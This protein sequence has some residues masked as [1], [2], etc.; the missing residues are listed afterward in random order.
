MDTIPFLVL[1]I[2]AALAALTVLNIRS[3]VIFEYQRGLLY[4][5]GKFVRVLEPGRHTYLSLQDT[6]QRIDI[7]TQYIA[8]PGQELLSA[9]HIALKISLAASYVVTDPRAAI[10][11]VSNYV[12]ALYTILQIDLRDVVGSLP[13]DD[14]LEKREEIGKAV[15]DRSAPKA[16]ELGLELGMV[17]L[18]DIMLPG[19]LKNIFARVVNARKEGLAAL[20]RARGESAALR[21]LANAAR[22]LEDNPNLKQLRMMQ[23]LEGR[24]GN[25][26]VLMGDHM[27]GVEK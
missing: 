12:N 7:R 4:R 17:N 1:I 21:N 5:N 25:T 16:K 20:E 3:I 15:F 11:Q 14:L 10:N 22:L 26:I 13:V 23:M 27:P 2:I 8:L 19:E 18:R 9:D 6:V 24:S